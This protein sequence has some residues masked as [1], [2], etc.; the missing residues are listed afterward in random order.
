MAIERL[1]SQRWSDLEVN[2]PTFYITDI[3]YIM[4]NILCRSLISWYLLSLSS[5]KNAAILFNVPTDANG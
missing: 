4:A 5:V 3:S 2:F 1:A